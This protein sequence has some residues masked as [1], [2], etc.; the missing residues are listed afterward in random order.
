MASLLVP[1]F[2]NVRMQQDGTYHIPSE[3]RGHCLFPPEPPEEQHGGSCKDV[4]HSQ[5]VVVPIFQEADTGGS[6]SPGV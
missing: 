6:L 2:E 3:A 1:C 4:H 5:E